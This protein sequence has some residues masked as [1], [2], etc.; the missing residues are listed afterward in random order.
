[1]EQF[2]IAAVLNIWPAD[3]QHCG[4]WSVLFSIH[5]PVRKKAE[6]KVPTVPKSKCTHSFTHHTGAKS[7]ALFDSIR[8]EKL[9]KKKKKEKALQKC[10]FIRL[11]RDKTLSYIFH[12]LHTGFCNLFLPSSD[13]QA[14]C[15]HKGMKPLTSHEVGDLFLLIHKWKRKLIKEQKEQEAQ[16]HTGRAL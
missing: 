16:D 1:M 15:K 5:T 14:V 10:Q 2:L 7:C 6:T 8:K 13:L 3:R 11:P 4:H 9:S 12:A